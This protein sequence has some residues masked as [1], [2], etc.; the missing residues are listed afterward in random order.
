[1]I[2]A[3]RRGWILAACVW[4]TA[5]GCGSSTSTGVAA[6][7][8]VQRTTGVDARVDVEAHVDVHTDARRE[9]GSHPDAHA[10]APTRPGDAGAQA[11]LSCPPFEVVV[12]QRRDALLRGSPG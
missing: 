9:A 12:A 6:D 11:G 4:V 7:G 5:S 10:D 2:G 1:M 3:C 8:G